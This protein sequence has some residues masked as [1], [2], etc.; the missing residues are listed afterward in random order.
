[1]PLAEEAGL[2]VPIG[3]WALRSACLQNVAW[4]AAGLPALRM[5]VKL[6]AR[7]LAHPGMAESILAIVKETGIDQRCLDLEIA[8]DA[9]AGDKVLK[10]ALLGRLRRARRAHRRSPVSAPAAPACTRW[11]SCRWTSSSSTA[12]S[13]RGSGSRSRT[14]R[15]GPWPNRSSTWPTACN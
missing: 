11:P 14:N 8:E 15:P 3:E 4:R 6:C 1:M 5:T 9:L 7:Q 13:S 12:V 10:S 2:A